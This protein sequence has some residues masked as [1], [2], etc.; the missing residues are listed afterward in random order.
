MSKQ[1]L[2]NVLLYGILDMGY[3]DEQKATEV[4]R[5]LIAGGAGALQ[6]RAKRWGRE[7]IAAMAERVLPITRDAGV[8]LI[9]NDYPEVAV[10]VGADGVHVGQDDGTID[11]IRYLVGEDMLIGRSTHTP[12][13]AEAALEDGFDYIGFGPVFPTPTKAGR[14]G[15]GMENIQSVH[16]KVGVEIPMFCIGGIKPENLDQV[17]AAGARRVVVVS[18]LL[19]AD[20]I[21]ATTAEVVAKLKG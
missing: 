2:S 21:A 3:V 5:Q 1:T 10:E 15:I 14:P 20:D 11:E 18:A 6:I 7:R 4:T 8:P 9:I 12:A 16:E 13:Q 19:Q 17:I